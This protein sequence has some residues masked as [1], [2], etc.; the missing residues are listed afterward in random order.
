M[1]SILKHTRKVLI[2]EE[3]LQKLSGH[4]HRSH[5]IPIAYFASA[6]LVIGMKG[7]PRWLN[8]KSTMTFEIALPEMASLNDERFINYVLV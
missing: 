4:D 6:M 3:G 8:I 1:L 2:W 7:G 5:S